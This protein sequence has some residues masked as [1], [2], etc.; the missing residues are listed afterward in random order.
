MGHKSEARPVE[1]RAS[2]DLRPGCSRDLSTP[3]AIQTQF[4]M[5]AHHVR[6]ELAT[7]VAALAF[8]GGAHG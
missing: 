5:A 3:I 4:L 6:P 1:G 2:R 7:L 8:G